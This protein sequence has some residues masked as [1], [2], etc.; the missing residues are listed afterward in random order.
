MP[1]H[2]AESFVRFRTKNAG[3]WAFNALLIVGA[4]LC[5][6]VVGSSSTSIL[7]TPLGLPWYVL[8][9][10][11]AAAELCLFS[12]RYRNDAQ[13]FAFGELTYVLG[14]VFYPPRQF[15]AASAIGL[16]L[17][18]VARR[19]PPMRMVFNIAATSLAASIVIGVTRAIAGPNA[20]TNSLRL[21]FGFIVGAA[22]ACPVQAALVGMVRSIAEHRIAALTE[23]PK[24]V[25]F[26]ELN[27]I[28]VASM[29]VLIAIVLSVA[30]AVA[31]VGL[32][33][34]GLLYIAFSEL[35]REHTKRTNVEFLYETAQSIHNTADIE[36]ALTNLLER[37]LQSFHADFGA[38]LLCRT[39]TKQWMG[40]CVGETI[41]GI[42]RLDAAPLWMPAPGDA[43]VIARQTMTV[44]ERKLVDQLKANHLLVSTLMV[45]NEVYGLLVV[46]DH[47]TNNAP[48]TKDDRRL[49]ESLANQ[50][51]IGVENSHLE[52]SLG[53]LTRLEEEVRYQVNHDSLTGLAN[54]VMLDGLLRQLTSKDRALLL[55]DL[56]DFKAVNDSLGHGA[57]D[58][59]LIEVSNRL[60]NSVRSDDLVARLGGDEFAIVLGTSATYERAVEV[61]ERL[62]ASLAPPMLICGRYVHIHA[63]VGVAVVSAGVALE[64]LLRSADVAMYHAKNS[65]KGKHRVFEPG[66]D[67][68]ARQRL[69]IITGL[70]GAALN[71]QLVVEYQPIVNLQTQTTVAVEALLRWD[72]PELG[73]LGPDR[74]I[75]FA[76]E[77]GA[78]SS[79]GR[80]TLMRACSDI[81]G[82]TNE[83]GE[84]L[85]L[86]VNVSPQQLAAEDFVETVTSILAS[87]FVSPRRLVLEIT[88]KTALVDSHLVFDNVR[89]LRAH[90]IQLALDD[91]GTGY[92]SLAAAH[93]FPLDLIKI[94]QL[95]VR[96]ITAQSEASLVKAILAM[97]D[98]L[99]LAAVAEGIETEEQLH[100]LVA[101]GCPL[102]QGYL[103]SRAISLVQL[104][105]WQL[106]RVDPVG[107]LT[108]V[109]PTRAD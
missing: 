35:V 8:I 40:F 73:R 77:S 82:L 42:T 48:F 86:H 105:N 74:F 10:V 107:H 100:K 88:E 58:D 43:V 22:I 54:R 9:V 106:R 45:E 53:V 41:G 4:L 1:K 13:T 83:Q 37:S 87:T 75:P 29:G 66:M 47:G 56:D 14:A 76:E 32:V 61:A 51:A 52:R 46:A 99:E 96:A 104:K 97:A 6:S 36:Q 11:S 3:V 79:L 98:S 102:G 24:V 69:Q 50:V 101:L 72:H 18:F 67:D 103:F 63:S 57:G 19:S 92:S 62:A 28:A 39:D 2:R 7:P 89:E 25:F 5:A 85:E 84:P 26:S 59:V 70:E 49:F 44:E 64:E 55:I 91:F 16:A 38:V 93:S 68:S 90:G 95:F 15:L 60:R 21:W 20:H 81:A 33:P 94:D 109:A 12:V 71:N 80:W 23:A 108:L 34:L 31:I 78:I 30:P 65:G 27:S 17:V